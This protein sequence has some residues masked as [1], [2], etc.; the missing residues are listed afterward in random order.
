M[1]KN[2]VEGTWLCG[3]VHQFI[4]TYMLQGSKLE[5]N[6]RVS[7]WTQGEL[8]AGRDNPPGSMY[9]KTTPT[10][11]PHSMYTRTSWGS[12]F[13]YLR[14]HSS[15]STPLV[16]RYSTQGWVSCVP[17]TPVTP[18]YTVG[19]VI[20]YAIINIPPSRYLLWH[21]NHRSLSC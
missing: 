8:I 16:L 1:F 5:A 15:K 12:G 9:P 18:L 19:H 7:A 17:P 21:W 3:C 20:Y 4:I 13:V 10:N 2:W 14:M 6:L 11:T